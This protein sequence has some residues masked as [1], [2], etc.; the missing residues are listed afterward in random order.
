MI[1]SLRLPTTHDATDIIRVYLRVPPGHSISA[2]YLRSQ[3][4]Y[5]LL[6]PTGTRADRVELLRYRNERGEL[7][8]TPMD[9]R[10]TLIEANGSQ[11]FH[12][13][14]P[15]SGKPLA[16]LFGWSWPANDSAARQEALRRIL[17]LGSRVGTPID[18]PPLAGDALR[19]LGRLNDCAHCHVANQRRAT[20]IDAAPL[21]RR[22][23]DASGFYVPLSVLHSKG[24]LAA[25]RPLDPNAGD[26]YV[27]VRCGQET[28]RLVRDGDWIWY[29]CADGSVP[30]GRREVRAAL[31]AGDPY[32]AAIC[33]SRRYLHD[34][35]DSAARR[36]FA[37]SFRECGIRSPEVDGP[38]AGVT[39][40]REGP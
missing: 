19:A 32:T 29:R 17:D 30:V 36:A 13:L 8:E 22:A 24:A 33:R 26:P 31:A 39:P 38:S 15:E 11:R 12:C 2:R 37:S 40:R 16:P 7:G 18:R 23:T 35:M 5:T 4:R 28:A 27:D 21:P 3:G 14:R 6:F 34:H 25:T 20:S 9:V 1:P 10:G